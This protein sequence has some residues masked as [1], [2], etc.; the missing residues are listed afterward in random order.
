MKRRNTV[1][2]TPAIGARTVA[3]SIGTFPIITLAGTVAT[4]RATPPASTLTG[5]SQYLRTCLGANLDIRWPSGRK[6]VDRFVCSVEPETFR[7]HVELAEEVARG[8]LFNQDYANPSHAVGS[9]EHTLSWAVVLASEQGQVLEMCG[10]PHEGC[11]HFREVRWS[12]SP[13]SNLDLNGMYLSTA[14]TVDGQDINS[15]ISV[16]PR[17]IEKH[18]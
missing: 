16:R 3:G 13:G 14:R 18:L 10:N 17:C 2:V 6:S 1:S 7:A 12:Q 4:A 11:H 5:F 8:V 15:A 9:I